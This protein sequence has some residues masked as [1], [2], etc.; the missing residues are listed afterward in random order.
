MWALVL[1]I[2]CNEGGEDLRSPMYT[3]PTDEPSALLYLIIRNSFNRLLV[4]V[5]KARL[6]QAYKPYIL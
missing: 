5:E 6:S 2:C 3:T 4:A 1:E